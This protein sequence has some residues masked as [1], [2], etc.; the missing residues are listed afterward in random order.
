MD[1][2]IRYVRLTNQAK[3]NILCNKI[4]YVAKSIQ[5]TITYLAT[6][7]RRKLNQNNSIKQ[8][9]GTSLSD[10]SVGKSRKFGYSTCN[11]LDTSSYVL[12]AYL[13]L[14][15]YIRIRKRG[16]LVH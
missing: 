3:R 6:S 10:I 13:M 1:K 2:H 4:W 15:E 14:Y 12:S 8:I 5:N 16:S 9:Y 11:L 7:S